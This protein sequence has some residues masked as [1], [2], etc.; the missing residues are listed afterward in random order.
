MLDAIRRPFKTVAL[1]AAT[2]GLAYDVKRDAVYL[3]Q[4]QNA[5]LAV[6]SL[7]SFTLQAPLSL[8]GAPTFEQHTGID[9]VPGWDS[10]VVSRGYLVGNPSLG[11]VNLVSGT[12]DSIQINGTEGVGDLQVVSTRKVFVFGQST[13]SGGY[14]TFGIW[15]DDLVTGTQQR[16]TDVGLGGNVGVQAE[17][18]RSGDQTKLLAWDPN[19]ACAQIY[20]VQS[21]AFSACKTLYFPL[22]AVPAGTAS[23]D[24]WL[25]H[26]LLFDGALN[27]LATVLPSDPGPG[28]IAPDGSAAYYPTLYGYEKVRLPDGVVLERVRIPPNDARL[29]V[30]PDGLRLVL[31]GAAGFTRVT[32]VDLR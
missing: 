1:G 11:V 16:R 31:S 23:G 20:D 29:T 12:D 13:P 8:P 5:Q 28:T 15:E 6:L 27:L 22:P 10:V 14:V 21:D 24:R 25:V 18:A 17:I 19:T 7:G 4:P 32:V 9:M 3:P 30:L 26:N 2:T